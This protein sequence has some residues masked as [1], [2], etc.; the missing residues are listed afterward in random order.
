MYFAPDPDTK[1]AE[2]VENTLWDVVYMADI[3]VATAE[4]IG[5]SS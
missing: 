1:I 4:V 2:V 3:S 5:H